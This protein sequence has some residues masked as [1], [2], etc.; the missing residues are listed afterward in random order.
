MKSIT[1]EKINEQLEDIEKRLEQVLGQANQLVGMKR[2]L[3]QQKS[4][5][6]T[7]EDGNEEEE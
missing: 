3:E 2:I 7:V 4:M 5:I 1:L 6:L